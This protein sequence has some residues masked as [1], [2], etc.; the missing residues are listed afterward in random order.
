M[1][2]IRML[3]LPV[4]QSTLFSTWALSRSKLLMLS[5]SSRS[6]GITHL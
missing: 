4:Q 3:D 2:A 1:E 5:L 6:K